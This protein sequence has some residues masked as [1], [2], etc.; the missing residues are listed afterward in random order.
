[1]G[2]VAGSF[3]REKILLQHD[4]SRPIFRLRKYFFLNMDLPKD[5]LTDLGRM[6]FPEV[7]D[8]SAVIEMQLITDQ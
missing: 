6:Y 2:L 1:M 5:K 3:T 7:L 8:H 4:F